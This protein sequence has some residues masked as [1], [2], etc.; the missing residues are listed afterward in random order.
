MRPQ[1]SF[2]GRLV[3]VCLLTAIIGCGQATVPPP[4]PVGPTTA[5]ATSTPAPAAAPTGAPGTPATDDSLAADPLFRKDIAGK[6]RSLP[7]GVARGSLATDVV[8]ALIQERAKQV[9]VK[10]TADG[11]KAALGLDPGVEVQ[12]VLGLSI[13]LLSGT[14]VVQRQTVEA[15]AKTVVR[16]LL[17]KALTEVARDDASL[18]KLVAD[19]VGSPVALSLPDRKLMRRYAEQWMYVLLGDVVLF[20]QKPR[21][22]PACP[23]WSKRETP[24]RDFCTKLGADD[25][26]RGAAMKK[27]LGLD[28][29]SKDLS[30][31]SMIADIDGLTDALSVFSKKGAKIGAID[32]DGWSALQ[33]PVWGKLATTADAL[34]K[35][36]KA[37]DT[38]VASYH[39]RKDAGD[40]AAVLAGLEKGVRNAADKLRDSFLAAKD[41]LRPIVGDTLWTSL[42]AWIGDLATE[43]TD[44]LRIAKKLGLDAEVF[45]GA[46]NLFVEASGS[47]KAVLN[48]IQKLAQAKRVIE[49]ALFGGPGDAS[50][51]GAISFKKVEAIQGG[52]RDAASELEL[53]VTQMR[54][55][56]VAAQLVKGEAALEKAQGLF[57]LFE[58]L[59]KVRVSAFEQLPITDVVERL[60]K[61]WPVARFLAGELGD[62]VEALKK[63]HAPTAAQVLD[64][65]MRIDF[66]RLLAALGVEVQAD[67]A[68]L[69]ENNGKSAACWIERLLQALRGSIDITEKSIKVDG[70]RFAEGVVSLGDQFKRQNEWHWFFHLTVGMGGLSIVNA[71]GK[72]TSFTVAG[73][74]LTRRAESTTTVP[75]I[76]E[77]IGIGYASPSFCGDRLAF[78]VGAFG[79]GLLYR[80][81]L[82]TEE[83]EAFMMGGFVAFDLYEALELYAA[84][85]AVI[86]PPST[87]FDATTRFGV[88]FG[89]Q[90]PLGDY[91]TRLVSK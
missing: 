69:C 54:A 89:A 21:S 27:A 43:G 41:L 57:H 42:G 90:V 3:W 44:M 35:D 10:I 15:L 60:A 88:S 65:V 12:D 5:G 51:L 75:L 82:D 24:E 45:T 28:S 74:D 59:D 38:L 20:S 91:L 76:A 71:P 72:A 63:G 86:Y 13:E 48:G 83:S 26:S 58:L 64:I 50:N 81:V 79:S 56:K 2:P 29:L 40:T 25:T 46:N 37:L 66:P 19:Q 52:L 1:G 6:K 55:L 77:Q 23:D 70:Q 36:I 7:G 22:M 16:A 68:S 47:V 14:T 49:T 73:L 11:L 31:F 33:D 9:A 62:V 34:G 78:K 53:M 87:P 4:A 30:A 32:F 8:V 67:G 80:M 39:A 61:F 85:A 17:A 18:D 84:P